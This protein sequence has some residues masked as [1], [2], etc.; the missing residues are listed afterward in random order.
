MVQPMLDSSKHGRDEEGSMK[1]RSR[2]SCAYPAS[3]LY[4]SRGAYLDFLDQVV[5]EL[6]LAGK[7]ET[8]ASLV[9]F[10]AGMSRQQRDIEISGVCEE[11]WDQAIPIPNGED[12]MKLSDKDDKDILALWE[13]EAVHEN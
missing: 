11:C 8:S 13:V 7:D 2:E 12:Y 4:L 9:F 3:R 10:I 6:R 5:E 1:C